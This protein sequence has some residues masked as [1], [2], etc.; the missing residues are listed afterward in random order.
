M[1]GKKL[2]IPMNVVEHSLLLENSKR[3]SFFL[4]QFER[5][6]EF[7]NIYDSIFV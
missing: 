3:C 4:N 1:L 2:Q 7:I 6:E 5:V